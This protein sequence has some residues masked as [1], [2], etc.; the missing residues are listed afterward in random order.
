LREVVAAAALANARTFGGED[1]VG[2]HAFM[3]LAPAYEMSREMPADRRALPVLKVL[4]RSTNQIQSKGG[5]ANEVLHV[6]KAEQSPTD[7]S[8]AGRETLREAMR[9]QELERAEGLFAGMV[10]RSPT[11]AFNDLQ[12]LVQD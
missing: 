10:S 8:G 4:Y 2:F 11:Q 1:Y 6:V 3:A 7:T 5:R 12:A 9:R